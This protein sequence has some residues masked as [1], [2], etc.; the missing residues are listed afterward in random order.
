LH[1]RFLSRK[2]PAIV[3]VLEGQSNPYT[4]IDFI[5]LAGSQ[6]QIIH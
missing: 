5:G 2:K 3:Q 4:K 1:G 6:Q